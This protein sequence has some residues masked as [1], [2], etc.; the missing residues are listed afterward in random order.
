MTRGRKD[1]AQGAG[2]ESWDWINAIGC[3]PDQAADRLY[4]TRPT[5]VR[6]HVSHLDARY[7]LART[8]GAGADAVVEIGTSSGVSTAVICH[9][10]A[11]ARRAGVIGRAFEVRTYDVLERFSADDTRRIG[12]AA[13]EMLPPELLGHVVFR[14]PATAAAIAADLEPDSVDLMFVDA[15]HQHPWPTLDLLATLDTLRPGAEVL[16]HDINLP[17]LLPQ[18]AHWGAKYL[19]DGL[20]VKK[21]LDEGDS[22][23]NIGSI[24][25]PD[26]KGGLRE[27][28][29]G[30]VRA[31]EWETQVST[32]VTAPLLVVSP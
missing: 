31:H 32:Q 29:L 3:T 22:I 21:R 5:W 25:V 19:F 12:D 16:L 10:L 24:W 30:I 27:Q 4:G 23:P 6:G 1:P 15:N 8:L 28:L 14:N 9:G 18:A 7:L 26:D 13:R 20:E 17:T 11:L 2:R